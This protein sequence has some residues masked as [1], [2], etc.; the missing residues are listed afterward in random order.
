MLSHLII[1]DKSEKVYCSKEWVYILESENI[2]DVPYLE[3]KNSLR[4]GLPTEIRP[5]IWM[6]L[7]GVRGSKNQ[8]GNGY[9]SKLKEVPNKE[10]DTQIRKDIHRTY[11]EFK[12]FQ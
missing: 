10:W 11:S 9:Y 7:A 1:I 8:Y 4:N 12:Y 2:V 3:L 6:W 5:R